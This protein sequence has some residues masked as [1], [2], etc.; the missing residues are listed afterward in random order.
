MKILQINA[1]YAK[2]STGRTTREMHEWFLNHGV[3][4]Y[5]A[6]PVL[7]GLDDRG[8][9]I[10]GTIDH[11]VH[12]LMSRLS[13][14]QAY[15][16]TL[17]TRGLLRYMDMIVPDVVILR[18]LHSNYVNLPML[19][20]Y[21][22]KHH[23]ATVLVLHDS[24]F[25][26]GGCT[27]YIAPGCSRWLEKCGKCPALKGDICSYF[28]DRTSAVLRDRE[29]YFDRLRPLSIIGVSQWVADDAG[30]SVLK[31]ANFIKCIYNW[32]DLKTFRPKDRGM[33]KEKYGFAKDKF[34][35]LG[36]SAGW[37]PAKGINL[38][39][40]L[41]DRL[42]DQ[43]QVVLVGNS[44]TVTDKRDNIVYLPATNNLEQLADMYA[45]ADVFVNPT[46]QETFGKT[47]A[48]ALSCGTPVV[49]YNGTATP[50]LVGTD[51]KCGYL[52]HDLDAD[53]FAG[54]ILDIFSDG[55]E[56]YTSNC[57]NRAESMF[58]METNLQEYMELFKEMLDLTVA[59]S[60]ALQM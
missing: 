32:I 34:I 54:K 60:S 28:L 25:I 44:D 58:D 41:A 9:Q 30:R 49:A 12:A 5:V 15:F 24:W 38:F 33:L 19:L 35:V 43:M 2:S 45:M 17:P 56:R 47:T 29:K 53:R 21:L 4:S 39:H 37:S 14:K 20:K 16:S 46:I 36:V 57:R 50:E 51:G 55:V 40:K 11:K 22:A 59:A 8:Y 52:I 3:E 10:G 1:V 27:Y 13:G 26:T 18:N 7:A 6:A 48:E 42:P 23:I 31:N